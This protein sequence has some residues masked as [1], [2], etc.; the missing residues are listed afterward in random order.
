M[1]TP[2]RAE[3]TIPDPYGNHYFALYINGLEVAH[4]VECSGLKSTTTVFEIEEGGLNTR[5]HKRP[6]Q[7]K[8]ENIVLRTATVA[9]TYLLEWRDQILQDNYKTASNRRTGAIALIGNDGVPVRRWTF[10]NGW[11]VSWEGPSL[12]SAGSE[13][14]IETLEIAHDGLTISNS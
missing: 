10:S 6:G 5:V 1:T 4:F 14:S 11:P 9:S 12:N 2:L 3:D 8:W 13:L 7:S